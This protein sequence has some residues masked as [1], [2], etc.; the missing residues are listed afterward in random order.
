MRL[1]VIGF[2]VYGFLGMVSVC[3]A[4]EYAWTQK[5][6]MPTPRWRHSTC[7]VNGKIY[8]IGGTTS[9]PNSEDVWPVEVY[10]PTTDTWAK[11][12]DMLTARA[13]LSTS[14]VNGKIYAI[15]GA[16][17]PGASLPTVEEFDSATDT[18]TRKADMPASRWGLATCT[19]NGKIYAIGG[20][21]PGGVRLKTVEEYDPVTDTWT[22]KADMPLGIFL[23]CANVV[24]GKIYA[25]GGRPFTHARPNVQEY[26]P[27]TDT[28][29][30]KADML[31]GTSQMGSVVLNDKI[32]VIGG[33]EISYNYPYTTVQMYDPE[34]DIWTREADVPFLRA[35][36]SASV[37][38]NRIY[39]IGG[40][41]RP[42]PCPATST[43]YESGPV[44][45]FNGDGIVNAADMCI[46]VDYWGTDEPLCDI[47]PMPWGDGIVDVQ[48]LIVLAEHLF[49]EPTLV[50]YWPFDEAQGEIAY[51]NAGTCD[52]TLL[53][54]PVWQ[55]AGGMLAGALQFDGI[56]DYV[57]TPFVLNPADGPFSV[58]AWVKGGAPGQ[59]VLSQIG[60]AN[61]LCTDSLEGNL[62]TGLSYPAGGRIRP[63]PL[64]SEFVITDGNWHRIGLV[65]DGSHRTLY[66]DDVVVAEDTQ[67]KLEGSDGGLYIS[68]GTA[69][70]P[71]SF[72]SGLIDDVR[73]YY[74]VVKP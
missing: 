56:D 66:V 68:T 65:W 40:T 6:D 12:A 24:R 67:A 60:G 42:H 18:W 48:D 63:Q 19:V 55:P 35:C 46:M 4:W 14:V 58:F 23:L 69:M 70:E 29:T 45:D 9:E 26:D 13:L 34:T 3:S 41:N 57:E 74:R 53:G 72:W 10:D 44:L 51:D 43:V 25:I 73:I 7:V 33:W 61:W 47:G 21:S 1:M 20:I 38:N 36:F 8:V 27:A 11:K 49:E 32:I 50:A 15:G 54:D 17:G 59:V 5:T 2:V 16:N 62:M 22:S 37:V 28:W 64:V 30:R 71:G 52:G 39:A 31:V